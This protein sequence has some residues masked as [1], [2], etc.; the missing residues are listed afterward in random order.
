MAGKVLITGFDKAFNA[1]STSKK[2][3]IVTPLYM[4]YY[5][6]NDSIIANGTSQQQITIPMV[7]RKKVLL[8]SK[9]VLQEFGNLE[10][11]PSLI[12]F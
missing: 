10:K 4:F 11:P 2:Q 5:F 3:Q 8:P 7:S 1:T 12:A 6:K 9:K